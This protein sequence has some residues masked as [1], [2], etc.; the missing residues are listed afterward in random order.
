MGFLNS[1][2]AA[3]EI[4][5]QN[6]VS[7]ILIAL[8]VSLLNGFLLQDSIPMN[9]GMMAQEVGKLTETNNASLINIFLSI[10]VSMIAALLVTILAGS[11]AKGETTSLSKALKVALPLLPLYVLTMLVVS[12]IVGFGTILLIVPGIIFGI[13]LIFAG[14]A[15]ALKGLVSTKAL[16]YSKDLVQGRWWYIFWINLGLIGL[17]IF[18]GVIVT[19]FSGSS[20]GMIASLIPNTLITVVLYYYLTAK[21]ALFVNLDN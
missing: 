5:Q 13:Y 9:P 19:L 8:T 6:L 17:N 14:Q 15:I 2:T 20:A 7:Y 18:I 11:S 4:L 21:T 1:L 3:W 10:L 16:L 12:L